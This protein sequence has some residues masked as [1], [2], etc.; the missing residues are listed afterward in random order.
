MAAPDFMGGF[1]V[2][3]ARPGG[4][5]GSEGSGLATFRWP[6]SASQT[7]R[8]G[9]PAQKPELISGR[10]A[11]ISGVLLASVVVEVQVT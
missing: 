7:G 8:Q 5:P 11:V 1:F 6:R 2:S 3:A 4:C 9:Q 10:P